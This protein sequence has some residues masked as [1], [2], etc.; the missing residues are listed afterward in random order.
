M[1][2]IMFAAWLRSCEPAWNA[3]KYGDRDPQVLARAAAYQR[4]WILGGDQ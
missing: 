1:T 3:A 4:F 2:P